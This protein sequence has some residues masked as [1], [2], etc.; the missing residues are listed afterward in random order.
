MSLVD[1]VDAWF[2]RAPWFL[3]RPVQV[4]FLLI[5]IAISPL[6][7]NRRFRKWFLN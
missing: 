5:V 2:N 1:H 7:L 4:I 3:T 6:M